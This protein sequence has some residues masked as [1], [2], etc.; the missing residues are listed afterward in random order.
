M[1]LE[2]KRKVWTRDNVWAAFH[3]EM[4][5]K[6]VRRDEMAKGV[7]VDSEEKYSQDLSVGFPIVKRT[8]RWEKSARLE[9]EQLVK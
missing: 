8:E 6:A 5:F 2:F 3:K 7:S 9:K 1:S 4:I